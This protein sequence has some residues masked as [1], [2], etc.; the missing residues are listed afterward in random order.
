M[1]SITSQLGKTPKKY[2]TVLYYDGHVVQLTRQH[3][4]PLP[5]CHPLCWRPLGQSLSQFRH[6]FRRQKIVTV[7]VSRVNSRT[8]CSGAQSITVL[9]RH[10]CSS[11][12]LLSPKA[13]KLIDAGNRDGSR[14]RPPILCPLH[15]HRNR[16]VYKEGNPTLSSLPF[17]YVRGTSRPSGNGFTSA[18]V[19]GA[20]LM[21]S[22]A[23]TPAAPESANIGNILVSSSEPPPA[24]DNLHVAVLQRNYSSRCTA[25][26]LP[27]ASS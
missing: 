25:V 12:D 3:K 2:P 7:S 23:V 27:C 22:A 19:F 17:L 6:L 8:P 26:I 11:P 18:P 16:T 13:W 1:C 5:Y 24:S 14:H 21:S 20:V 10:K 4:H 9:C 15:L